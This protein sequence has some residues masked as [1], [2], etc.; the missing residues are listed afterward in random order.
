MK[1]YFF[2]FLVFFAFVINAQDSEEL[3]VQKT[4]EAFFEGFHKQDAT[5]M[6]S[7]IA[8][9]GVKLQSVWKD[10]EGKHHLRTEEFEKLVA[11]IVSIPDSI[12][13]TEKLFDFKI[14]VDGLMANVWVPYEFWYN[15]EFSH[16]GVNCIQLFKNDDEEWKIIYLIDTRRKQGCNNN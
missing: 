2:L 4:V 7:F 11:S 16:C 5:I 8:G 15:N 3:E 1:N 13:F 12:V 6:S 10:K 9:E 14:Q